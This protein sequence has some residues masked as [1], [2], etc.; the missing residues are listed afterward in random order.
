[1]RALITRYAALEIEILRED[2]DFS[3]LI[4]GT[5]ILQEVLFRL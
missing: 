1:M 3:G 4:A 2:E 5:Q